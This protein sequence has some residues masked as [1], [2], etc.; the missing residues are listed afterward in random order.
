MYAGLRAA[1]NLMLAQGRAVEAFRASGAQ[2]EIGNYHALADIQPASERPEDVAAAERTNAYVNTMYLDPMMGR[3][4]PEKIVE[5]FEDAWPP[6][7]DGDLD[8]RRRWISSGSAT[9]ATRS[10]GPFLTQGPWS[11]RPTRRWKSQGRRRSEPPAHLA[12]A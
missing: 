4:Y 1:H 3:G 9:I 5:W 6:V 8:L 12:R 2:G 10:L 7:R 11:I